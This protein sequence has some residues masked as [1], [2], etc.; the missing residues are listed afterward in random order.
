MRSCCDSTAPVQLSRRVT[1]EDYPVD[2]FV[3]P[4]GRFIIASL[5]SSNRDE[6]VF[7]P[8]A[9][10]VRLDRPNAKQHVSFGGGVHHCLGTAL[11]RREG[12]AA[13][14]GLFRRFPDIALDGEVTAQRPHQ[15]A[16]ADAPTG[17]GA[18]MTAG[19]AGKLLVA[20]PTLESP[21]F[22]RSVIAMLEHNDEGALGV[23]INRPGDASLLEVVPPVAEIAS[24]P[25]VLFS[26]GPVEPQV[27]IALGVVEPSLT[28]DAVESEAWRSVVG[29]L[30]T[31]DL[32]YDPALLAAS[33]RELRV[34]AGYAGWSGGQLEG[35]IAEGAW[36]VV[37]R[38]PGDTFVDFP[39]RL[40]SAVLRR[41][42]WPLSR[43]LDLPVR[44]HDELRRSREWS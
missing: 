37:D 36:F 8:D 9:D 38:L 31:V 19:L 42:P 30:V 10:R 44:P 12:R 23:I 14:A 15:P 6:A 11:A 24:T 2:G 7:G 39:D 27:A 35:E 28:N 1:L 29:P 26:G 18:L 33:L 32:D 20:S 5:G 13:I 41:Q 21:A 40:W 17:A 3:V 16:G 25:A 34:F 4:K 22:A 43:G